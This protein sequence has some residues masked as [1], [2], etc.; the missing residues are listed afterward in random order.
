MS[1]HTHSECVSPDTSHR[2]HLT[3]CSLCLQGLYAAVSKPW[4]VAQMARIQL[5]RYVPRLGQETLLHLSFFARVEKLRQA[6]PDPKIRVS[7]PT[8]PHPLLFPHMSLAPARLFPHIHTRIFQYNHRMYL[9]SETQVLSHQPFVSPYVTRPH[10][11]Y[12]EYMF[13]R[14]WPS[15]TC[16]RI[17]KSSARRRSRS[18]GT[19]R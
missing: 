8:P 11:A 15:S 18:R 7:L 4:G 12:V 19:G 3:G 16:T 17:M 6:D 10:S 13:D 14:R 5:P 9:F 2:I 1:H